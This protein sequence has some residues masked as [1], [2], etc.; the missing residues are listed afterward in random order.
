MSEK[1]DIMN[2]ENHV[3]PHSYSNDELNQECIHVTITKRVKA[4]KG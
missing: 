1:V 4:V 3:S 2:F